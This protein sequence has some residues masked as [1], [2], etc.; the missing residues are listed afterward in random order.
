MYDGS[1]NA[2]ST[3]NLEPVIVVDRPLSIYNDRLNCCRGGGCSSRLM[4]VPVSILIRH[5]LYCRHSDT[6]VYWQGWGGGMGGDI[7]T[8]EEQ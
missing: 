1:I 2:S 5:E 4:A 6:G 7:S 3:N 8:L